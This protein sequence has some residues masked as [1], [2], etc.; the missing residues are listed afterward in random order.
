MIL[1]QYW[2]EIAGVRLRPNSQLNSC[3]DWQHFEPWATGTACVIDEA[4]AINCPFEIGAICTGRQRVFHR[5][6]VRVQ[7][8]DGSSAMGEH[9]HSL[10]DALY[11]LNDE[12]NRRHLALLAAGLLNGWYESGL[13]FNS[14]QGYMP[15]LSRTVHMMEVPPLPEPDQENEG[16]IDRLI[17]E[18]VGGMF[19]GADRKSTLERREHR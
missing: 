16:F 1:S 10:R 4:D 15:S 12:L 8:P 9:E 3:M 7:L 5:Y 14:G 13:S 6:F 17:R 11:A 18:A 19:R 2:K